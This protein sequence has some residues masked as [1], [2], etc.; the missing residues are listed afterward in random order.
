MIKLRTYLMQLN[1]V[2]THA[3]SCNTD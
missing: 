1:V 2:R 3:V